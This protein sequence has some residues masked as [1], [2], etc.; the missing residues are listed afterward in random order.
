MA[1]RG[2]VKKVVASAMVTVSPCK[3]LAMGVPVGAMVLL[4][5]NLE[6]TVA[7]VLLAARTAIVS[8][9]VPIKPFA[10]S[11]TV[12]VRLSEPIVGLLTLKLAKAVLMALSV[13]DRVMDLPDAG[14]EPLALKRPFLSEIVTVS[15]VVA[16]ANGSVTT[17]P[18]R[19]VAVAATIV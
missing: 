15:S 10:W 12:M 11:F 2:V 16:V 13:P 18:V 17:M 5:V 7:M 9:P 8:V 6:T 3:A 4:E 19:L 14:A 1:V